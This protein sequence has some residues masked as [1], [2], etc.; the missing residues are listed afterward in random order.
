MDPPAATEPFGVHQQKGTFRFAGSERPGE[1]ATA[2]VLGRHQRHPVAETGAAQLEP[3]WIQQ[4]HIRMDQQ[5]VGR[6]GAAQQGI[7]GVGLAAAAHHHLG[8]P[9]P[10]EGHRA[11]GGAVVQHTDAGVDARGG[12]LQGLQAVG[13]EQLTVPAGDADEEFG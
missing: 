4:D 6:A 12:G 10:G 11:V 2:D 13:Q 3:A 8:A 9:L 7:E 5:G 1:G